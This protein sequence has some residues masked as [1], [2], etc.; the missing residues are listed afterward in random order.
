MDVVLLKKALKPPPSIEYNDSNL[1]W[2]TLA[3]NKKEM[4]NLISVEE[5]LN[6]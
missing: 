1:T 5:F 2:D 6:K 4:L 3:F